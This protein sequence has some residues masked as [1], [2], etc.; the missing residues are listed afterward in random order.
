M[1]LTTSPNSGSE[2]R[3]QNEGQSGGWSLPSLEGGLQPR[4][5][6][7]RLS[8][9]NMKHLVSSKQPWPSQSP[10]QAMKYFF[11]TLG[12]QPSGPRERERVSRAQKEKHSPHTLYILQDFIL[13]HRTAGYDDSFWEELGKLQRPGFVRVCL[14]NMH[15]AAAFVPAFGI[16]RANLSGKACS[17]MCPHNGPNQLLQASQGL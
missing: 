16:I 15:L 2:S 17:L 6:S 1:A 8:D 10:W 13:P 7:P 3:L 4:P 11:P 12:V 5:V 14:W 9:C